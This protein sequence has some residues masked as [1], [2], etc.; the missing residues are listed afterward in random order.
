M[1]STEIPKLEMYAMQVTYI[2]ASLFANSTHRHSM[3]WNKG[4]SETWR[5]AQCRYFEKQSTKNSIMKWKLFTE[6]KSR[7]DKRTTLGCKKDSTEHIYQKDPWN[8][9]TEEMSS[10]RMVAINVPKGRQTDIKPYWLLYWL[11][12]SWSNGNR[13]LGETK[14]TLHE[15]VLDLY[16]SESK[17]QT[18]TI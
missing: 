12:M 15:N 6:I 11:S 2:T 4:G 18:S 7:Y 13:I 1:S 8:R 3:Y 5:D 14:A 17:L 9:Q 10:S 16:R